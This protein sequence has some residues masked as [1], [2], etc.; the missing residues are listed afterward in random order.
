MRTLPTI[1]SMLAAAALAMP[2]AAQSFDDAPKPAPA[3]TGAKRGVKVQ[4]G[5]AMSQ[6]LRDIGVEDARIRQV[7]AIHEKYATQQQKVRA[8]ARQ[9]RRALE[10]LVQKDSK[11]ETAYRRAL[12][13]IEKAKKE[14]LRLRDG[15]RQ[16]M[17]NVLKPS[18]QA[19]LLAKRHRGGPRTHEAQRPRAGGRASAPRASKPGDDSRRPIGTAVRAER[20]ESPQRG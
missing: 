10:N 18:E 5:K 17:R 9:H 8:D 1:A 15:E 14:R 12:D 6:A 11:D 19:K 20:R 4:K 13:G 3:Q 16:E 2:A 7:V